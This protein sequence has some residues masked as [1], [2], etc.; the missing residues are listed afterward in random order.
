MADN[1]NLEEYHIPVVQIT[2]SKP[3]YIPVKAASLDE[4]ESKAI[5]RAGEVEFADSYSKH[6]VQ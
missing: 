3:V 4:A 2:Y 1:S 5:E 6:S